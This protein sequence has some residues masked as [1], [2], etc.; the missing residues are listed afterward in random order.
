MSPRSALPPRPRR[1][2]LALGAGALLV[3]VAAACGGERGA[4]ADPAAAARRAGS[5][6][7]V[8]SL[9]TAEF[10]LAAGDSTYWVTSDARGVRV[11]AAPLFLARFDGTFHEVWA[12]D[13]DR[14]FASAV[15]TAQRLYRRDLA[16]ADSVPLWEDPRPDRLAAAWAR[17]HPDELPLEADE[18]A[19][20]EPELLAS[21]EVALLDVHGPYASVERHYDQER[22]GRPPRHEL[23]RSVLDLRTGRD[24]PLAALF[25]AEGAASLARAGRAQLAEA[26]RA[27]VAEADRRARA[28]DQAIEGEGSGADGD[29][30]RTGALADALGSART[31]ARTLRLDPAS[32]TLATVDGAPAVRFVARGTDARGLDAIWTLPPLVVP[33]AAPAWWR[34]DVAP[35]LPAWSRDS[36]V[37]QWRAPADLRGASYRL[38]ARVAG[39][40]ATLALAP[41]LAPAAL[42][43]AGGAGAGTTAGAAAVAGRLLGAFPAPVHAVHP[44]DRPPLDPAT[45]RALRRAFDASAF[46]DAA[47][48]S[49]AWRHR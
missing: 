6:G 23:R 4:P 36:A 9:P 29:D 13:Q 43:R 17:A 38:R 20:E 40:R 42:A 45:R 39:G 48:T 34:R 35:T 10:L 32:F 26:R 49:V 41:D 8:P 33:G 12:A 31:A 15:F 28:A 18:P 30:A 11:R 46:F 14:S 19:D 5:T 25:G 24:V 7:P 27:L 37:A 3:A 16:E 44:L 1:T 22:A 47:T 21:A 2:A